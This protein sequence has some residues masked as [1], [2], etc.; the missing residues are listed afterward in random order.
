MGISAGCLPQEVDLAWQF[1]QWMA[2]DYFY[3]DKDGN[4]YLGEKRNDGDVKMGAG[5]KFVYDNGLIANQSAL[6]EDGEQNSKQL[7]FGKALK[8]STPYDSYYAPETQWIREGEVSYNSATGVKG[9]LMS[10]LEWFNSGII[11]KTN[12]VLAKK[13]NNYYDNANYFASWEEILGS[14]GD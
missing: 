10:V 8:N 13:F 6:Y 3:V 9:G 4:A 7:V 14:L 11:N 1:I 2:S 5:Q 12:K